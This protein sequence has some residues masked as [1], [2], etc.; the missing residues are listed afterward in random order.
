MR[1]GRLA[2]LTAAALAFLSVPAAGARENWT[3]KVT[4]QPDG[5]HVLGNP[6]AKV[7]LTE[8]VSY[9]CPHCAHFQQ[10]AEAPMRLAYVMPGKLSVRVAHV[11]RDPVDLTVAMLTNCG[12]P[13]GFFKRHHVFLQGQDRWLAR[14]GAMTQAQRRRWNSGDTPSRLRAIAADFDFYELMA[15]RGYSRAAVDRC[16]ADKAM[17][18]RLIAQTA[19]A[20]EAGVLGTPSFALDG[21]LLAATHDWQ[22]LNVQIRARM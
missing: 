5:S 6:A 10:D 4:V 11:I 16:L 17:S 1:I 8:Y 13:A 22:S 9:T 12:D 20:Q 21:V 19:A 2:T 3:A 18:E 14:M 7:K 15:Q